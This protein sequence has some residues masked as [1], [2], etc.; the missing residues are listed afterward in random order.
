MGVE[1]VGRARAEALVGELQRPLDLVA[2]GLDAD[3]LA[4]EVH[5]RS[6]GH[7]ARAIGCAPM[8][9]VDAIL[10]PWWDRL[11]EDARASRCSTPTPTSGRTTRT[12][13]SRRP[14][15]CSTALGGGRRARRRVP[16]ARAGRLPRG[17]RRRDRTRPRDSDGTLVRVLPRRPARPARVAEA[18][19]CLDAGAAGSSCTRA[20]S[21]SR[22]PSPAC[23][24]SSRSPTSARVPVLIHAGRGIPALGRGHG[25][26]AGEFPDA[27]LILAHAAISDLAWL[28]RV[29]PDHPNVFIDTAWWNPADLIAL[30]ALAPPARSCGRATRPTGCRSCRR[31]AAL[32]CALQAGLTPTQLRGGRGRADGALLAGED[33]ARR[34]APAPG[35]PRRRSTRCSSASSPT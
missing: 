29:L 30:F 35:A 17:Q 24:S 9:D 7:A 25:R 27:R 8:L 32:R 4:A 5:V 21:S 3:A 6:I 14:R 20:P 33:P 34:S 28:W 11:A 22:W 10:R 15:S 12:A 19:R 26:L 1:E 31:H 16:D 23:A 18:R 2:L 13:S